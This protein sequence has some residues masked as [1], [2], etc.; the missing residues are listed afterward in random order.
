MS[1]QFYRGPNRDNY[2]ARVRNDGAAVPEIFFENSRTWNPY[3]DLDP[4]TEA[5]EID[6][7]EA[8]TVI[9]G[10]TAEELEAT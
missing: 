7:T 3:P 5:R 8:L 4:Q 1:T 10:M 9:D 2:L 6:A